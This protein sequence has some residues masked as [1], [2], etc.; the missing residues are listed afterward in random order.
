MKDLFGADDFATPIGPAEREG[1]I[2]THVALRG[3]LNELEQF[4]I[5]DASGWAFERKR[6]VLDERFLRRLHGRMFNKVWRWA[7]EYR[8][9]E[10]NLGVQPHL[11]QPGLIQA[12]DD[13]R[14]WIEYKSYESDELAVRFHHKLVL[15][16]PFPN[17]N[18]R[19]SRLAADL[20]VVA[21]GVP[22]FSWGG[23]NLQASGN[24]RKDYI[25]ALRAADNH[26]FS[27][28]V[29]FARS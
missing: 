12:I 6:N 21:R 17:G 18:G 20:L 5:A 25:N 8:K 19:W 4:N 27:M 23:A 9:T 28:L 29:T 24:V 2:P 16:H 11:I 7:G 22:R 14:S 13:A 15:V 3:E 1:L 10:R 26:D